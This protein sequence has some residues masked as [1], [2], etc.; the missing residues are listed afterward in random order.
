MYNARFLIAPGKYGW[1][2]LVEFAY[3]KFKC[4]IPGYSRYI[5]NLSIKSIYKIKHNVNF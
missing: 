1:K 3:L 2:L 4:V 5:E